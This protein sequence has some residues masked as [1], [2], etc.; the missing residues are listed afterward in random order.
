[1][2]TSIFKYPDAGKGAVERMFSRRAVAV[3]G[4]GDCPG[5]AVQEARSWIGAQSVIR[6]LAAR[7]VRQ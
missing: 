1:M 3:A 4:W 7:Q 6:R 2:Q 5:G